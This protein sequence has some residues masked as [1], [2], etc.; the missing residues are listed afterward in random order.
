MERQLIDLTALKE[1]IAKPDYTLYNGD[2]RAAW[3]EECIQ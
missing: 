1:K 2:M 3:I